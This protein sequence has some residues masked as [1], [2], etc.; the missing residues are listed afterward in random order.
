MD[1]DNFEP[2]AISLMFYLYTSETF[3]PHKQKCFTLDF[4][5]R[6]SEEGLSIYVKARGLKKLA[7][8]VVA[9]SSLVT[10]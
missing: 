6:K 1:H 7:I 3:R 4:S 8:G 9:S 2:G 5:S 10:A